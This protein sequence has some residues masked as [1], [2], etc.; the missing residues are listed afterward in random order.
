MLATVQPAAA[1][2]SFTAVGSMQ[3]KRAL[4]TATTLDDGSVLVVGGRDRQAVFESLSSAET[5]DP[6]T[7]TFTFTANT[8]QLGRSQHTATLLASGQVLV[9]GGENQ[10]CC[11]SAGTYGSLPNDTAD[12]YDP[13]SRTF[14]PTANR[15][16]T[17]RYSHAATRLADGR[18]LITGG[19]TDIN[20]VFFTFTSSADIYDPATNTFTP[21]GPMTTARYA[22]ASVLLPDGKV[23]I[24]GGGQSSTTAEVFDPATGT[25]TATTNPPAVASRTPVGFALSDGTVVLFGHDK[26]VQKYD[27]ASQ[28]FTQMPSSLHAH[29]FWAARF[30]LSNEKILLA[31]NFTSEI[32]N[33]FTGTSVDTGNP[34][35]GDLFPAGAAL[36]GGRALLT[37]GEIFV[38]FT[39]VSQNTASVFEPNDAPV[40]SAGPDQQISA[41]AGCGATV[42]LDG[43]ASSDPDGD[44]LTY[45]WTSGATTIGSGATLSIGVGIGTH[46][47]TLTVSDG[48]GATSTDT[49][50]IVVS[51]TTAPALTVVPAIMLEQTGPDGTPFTVPAPAATDNCTASPV[52][53]VSGLPA[54]GVFPPG[55]TTI[56][57]TA[58]D[59][60]GNAATATTTVTVR[61][62]VAPVIVSVE[63]SVT[64]LW[65]ANHK[66]V[67]VTFVVTASDV[68]TAAPVC[69]VT[70]V[71]SSEA[72]NSHEP[73][74]SID[75]PLAVRLRAERFGQGPGRVYTIQVRCAD[76]FGNA[77]TAAATVDVPHDQGR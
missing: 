21:T 7:G 69:T 55:Q 36:A 52:V 5:F 63:P 62:T 74:W 50:I 29:D 19:I 15:M 43:S 66:M 61:D 18:V 22:H 20:L 32:Y 30:A 13:A 39:F 17:V 73:D 10:A 47:I 2:G 4:H 76:A 6:S 38:P 34:G 25:F 8:M 12:V 67:S 60:A 35:V 14:A 58:T 44:S 23:L 26:L 64:K 27:P 70:G 49:T 45:T 68:A 28:T 46:V 42:T 16:S 53:S 41:G 3:A 59:A 54:N 48:S 40:A 9:T 57:Y 71:T 56:T 37:G 72:V 51:D 31:D 77:A 24:V 1:Q 75:G 33:P 11:T 65:P